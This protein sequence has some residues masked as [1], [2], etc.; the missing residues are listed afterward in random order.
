[1]TATPVRRL[2]VTG[3]GQMGAQIA[4][5]AAIG[6]IET[7][8]HDIDPGQL[9]RAAA[10]NRGHIGRRVAKGKMSQEDMEAAFSRLRTTSSLAEACAEVDFV[11]EAVVE[12]L[13]VKRDV[14]ARLDELAPPHAILATNSS[15]LGSSRIADA[16]SRPEKVLNMHFFYPPLVLKLVEVV[17]G[18]HTSDETASTTMELARVM[19]KVPVHLRKEMPGFLVNRILRAITNEAYS[20]LENGVADFA[21]IDRACE[22]G[23]NHPMGPFKLSDY[24][25]LDI[26]YNARLE[27]HRETGRSEDKPPAALERRVHRGDLGRKTGRGFYDWTGEKPRPTED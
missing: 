27:V 5:L 17:Q 26:G 14:F 13:D 22:M 21:D 8:L 3:A 6:G 24:S 1:M 19:G 23:L 4:M 15:Y 7:R 11:L 10:S 9:S 2:A 25:G 18:D 16:T 20:L 12:K